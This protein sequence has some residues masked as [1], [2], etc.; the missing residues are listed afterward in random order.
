MIAEG[1]FLL[2]ALAQDA[3]ADPEP[4]Q[5]RFLHEGACGAKACPKERHWKFLAGDRPPG[6]TYDFADALQAEADA[7][8]AGAPRPELS[9]R[10]VFFGGDR[11]V[12]WG[13]VL[14]AMKRCAQVGIYKI[15]WLK[16]GAEKGE[17]AHKFWLTD[18]PKNE[19]CGIANPRVT[20]LWDESQGGLVRRVGEKTFVA[21]ADEMI[22][23]LRA[24]LSALQKLGK[25]EWPVEIGAGPD[26]PWKH[27]IEAMDRCRSEGLE[28]QV[29]PVVWRK[30][31]EG[32]K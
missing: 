3:A 24:E 17:M 23:A 4:L 7:R 22:A 10:I 12:P 31:A 6:D 15:A 19:R 2:A 27:L 25:T 13:T 14:W 20:L 16:P 1:L 21:T 28:M 18:A 9:E 32:K 26:V 30:A 8:R 5:V 11:T 29:V